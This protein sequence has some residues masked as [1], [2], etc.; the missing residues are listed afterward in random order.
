MGL[1]AIFG[2]TDK[3]VR[4]SVEKADWADENWTE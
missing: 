3:T 4:L 1:F 2:I